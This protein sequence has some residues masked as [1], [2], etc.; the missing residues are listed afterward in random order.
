[1][2]DSSGVAS[3][4]PMR[5]PHRRLKDHPLA[6]DHTPMGPVGW[7]LRRRL[8]ALAALIASV[9]VVASGPAALAGNGGV[10]LTAGEHG[11]GPPPFPSVLPR[12]ATSGPSLRW[13]DI[14]PRYQWARTAVD[15]VGETND[16]MRDY[17]ANAD[18]EYP[19]RPGR[20]EPRRLFARALVRAL[21]P[22]EEQDPSITFTDVDPDS[23]FHRFA[24][25]AVKLGWMTRGRSG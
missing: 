16:W 8:T 1:M 12:R 21:A 13:S 19:F 9:L 10:D 4:G 15:W 7:G 18:G 5:M 24:N 3:V 20:L 17:R 6:A 23:Q 22:G 14:T 25:V 2:R 11:S